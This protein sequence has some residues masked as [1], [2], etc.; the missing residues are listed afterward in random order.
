MLKIIG[1]ALLFIAPCLLAGGI[2]AVATQ[3]SVNTWYPTL[4]KPWFTPPNWL[5]PVAWTILYVLMGVAAY[6]VWRE[7]PGVQAALIAFAV[8]LALNA[9]WSVVFFGQRSI[10]GG[11]VVIG[12]LLAAL[13]VTT[14][15]FYGHARWA[16]ILMV[17]YLLWVI[18]ATALNIAIWRM[19]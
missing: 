4:T 10:G 6:L 16:A 18:Y 1:Q 9:A 11:L 19:N 7:R 12:L 17:P 14:W 15:L 3:T 8:Q 2:G 5:F 13:I